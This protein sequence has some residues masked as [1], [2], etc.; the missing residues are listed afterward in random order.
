MK[1]GDYPPSIRVVKLYRKTS[2]NGSTYYTGRWGGAK[3][4]LLKTQEAA[5][6]GDEVWALLLSE[7]PAYKPAEQA[8]SP[9]AT[10]P[11]PARYAEQ[12]LPDDAVPF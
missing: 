7:A 10:S 6:N 9:A 5:D 11:A 3:V 4:A 8:S 2:R 12:M 1:N